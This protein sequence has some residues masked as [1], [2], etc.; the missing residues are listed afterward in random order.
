MVLARL[1]TPLSSVLFASATGTLRELPALRW[2]PS[3]VVNVVV[4]ASGYP[5][6]VRSGDPITGIDD[7]EALEGVHVLHAGTA[8]SA[9]G[10]LVSSGGRV[11]SVIAEGETFDDAR[12]RAY[13]GV[14]L[15]NLEGSHHR[16]DFG[17]KAARGEI[18]VPSL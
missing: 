1:R 14:S 6:T 4:A 9:D 17:L 11:L 8:L 10:E 13:E 2:S 12:A 5:A 18:T 7:A 16:T 3:P 15:I